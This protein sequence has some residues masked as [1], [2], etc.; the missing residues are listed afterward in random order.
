MRLLGSPY[1]VA[2]AVFDRMAWGTTDSTVLVVCEHTLGKPS[3][4]L[5]TCIFPAVVAY[6]TSKLEDQDPRAEYDR[7]MCSVDCTYEEMSDYKE[8]GKMRFW[9]FGA[10]DN[11]YTSLSVSTLANIFRASHE[12]QDLNMH[13]LV[14]RRLNQRLVI[15]FS[16]DTIEDP[17]ISA[18][19]ADLPQV[20]RSINGFQR[21]NAIWF[22]PAM[23]E[24]LSRILFLCSSNS[25]SVQGECYAQLVSLRSHLKPAL[26][27][28]IWELTRHPYLVTNGTCARRAECA[29][30]WSKLMQQLASGSM[31]LEPLSSDILAMVS[32]CAVCQQDILDKD[33]RWRRW[34]F[35]HLPEFIGMDG[36]DRL[37]PVMNE[38]YERHNVPFVFLPRALRCLGIQPE[39]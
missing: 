9:A 26:D 38:Y 32:K 29:A 23:L 4:H 19:A 27:N 34:Y 33:R 1:R 13:A 24:W 35:K 28:R 6:R 37:L 20:V 2:G 25:P 39:Q 31:G 5:S 36:W 14:L 21:V 3:V 16:S 8:A 30:R 7:L 22:I 10:N 17:R 12:V 11:L 18:N 15:A